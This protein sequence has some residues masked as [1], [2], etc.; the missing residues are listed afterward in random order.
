MPPLATSE[1]PML[2]VLVGASECPVCGFSCNHHTEY[3][4]VKIFFFL[5]VV[6]WFDGVFCL[7]SL[8][9]FWLLF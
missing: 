8:L 7:H 6:V 1:A 3:E 2:C 5:V 4:A 9:G